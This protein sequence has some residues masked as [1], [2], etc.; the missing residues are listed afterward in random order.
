VP[1]RSVSTALVA[2]KGASAWVTASKS[3][4]PGAKVTAASVL[5][6]FTTWLRA[7]ATGPGWTIVRTL[8]AVWLRPPPCDAGWA[9]PRLRRQ[10]RRQP[11]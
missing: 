5:A 11:Q 10:N 2:P 6:V 7:A 9:S 8:R 4:R 1:P 3:E